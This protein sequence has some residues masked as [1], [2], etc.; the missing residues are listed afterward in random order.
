MKLNLNR[1]GSHTHLPLALQVG[2]CIEEGGMHP[3][4]GDSLGLLK[5]D[6]AGRGFFHDAEAI[7]L[8]LA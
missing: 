4:L 6:N 5:R 2:Y 8:Q 1:L 3:G 7:D